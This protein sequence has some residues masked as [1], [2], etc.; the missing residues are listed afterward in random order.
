MSTTQ[1]IVLGFD[2]GGVRHFGWS[3][4]EFAGG[5]L[6]PPF[7]TGVANDARAALAKTREKIPDGATV[8]ASGIDS[9][10]FWTGT[11]RRDVDFIVR[12]ALSCNEFDPA[13][14]NGTVQHPNSLKG[15]CIAQG[16]LLARHLSETW[17]ALIISESHPRALRHLVHHIGQPNVAARVEGLIAGLV[18]DSSFEHRRDATLAAVSAWAALNGDPLVWQDL[19]RKEPDRIPLFGIDVS[20]WMPIPP[21]N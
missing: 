18:R 8:L 16:P 15:A 6:Q 7:A 20:Y 2:P 4:C 21:A 14:V 10:L 5:E 13:A 3:I 9:P 19:Y 12:R 17:R 11:G 1:E